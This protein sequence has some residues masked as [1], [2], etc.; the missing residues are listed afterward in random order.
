MVAVSVPT[1]HWTS[2]CH[3]VAGCDSKNQIRPERTLEKPARIR[4]S[5]RDAI[6]RPSGIQPLRGWLISIAASRLGASALNATQNSFRCVLNPAASWR[7]A[8][9]MGISQCYFSGGRCDAHRAR[10][11]KI[12]QLS[13]PLTAT[14]PMP[15]SFNTPLVTQPESVAT[16]TRPRP[17]SASASK[18]PF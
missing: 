6:L 11:R 13:C 8:A 12:S 1:G 4:A 14:P 5:L 7:P 18:Q 16:T 2:A 10:R 9:F 15:S 3:K 17:G